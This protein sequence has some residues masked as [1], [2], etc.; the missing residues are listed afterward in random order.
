MVT[1]DTRNNSIMAAVFFAVVLISGT[2]IWSFTSTL[3]RLSDKS[4]NDI[5]QATDNVTVAANILVDQQ[6]KTTDIFRE[7]YTDMINI[8][9][10]FV[11]QTA[12][13]QNNTAERDLNVSLFLQ[14]MRAI[15]ANITEQRDVEHDFI[16]GNLS[17]NALRILNNTDAIMKLQ[18]NRE[19][20]LNQNASS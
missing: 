1:S 11:R 4:S 16:L 6:N 17:A 3:E 2:L 7:G 12:I 5:T 13:E 14:T 18:Q 9:S 20:I 8:I 19:M 10:E 15:D